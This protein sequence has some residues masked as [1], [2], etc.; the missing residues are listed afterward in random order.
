[1]AVSLD[2]TASSPNG[3][4]TP[5]SSSSFSRLRR[6]AQSSRSDSRASA[7]SLLNSPTFLLAVT[8]GTFACLSFT[9]LWV[10]GLRG[11]SFAFEL[12]GFNGT[13]AGGRLRHCA[14]YGCKCGCLK[15][16]AAYISKPPSRLVSPLLWW[17]R[18]K[19]WRR[20]PGD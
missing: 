15:S 20:I 9:V 5:A 1:M 10:L 8:M 14:R 13:N 3:F 6:S 17:I 12:S 19:K 18:I 16:S 2:E 7:L 4:N 11:C